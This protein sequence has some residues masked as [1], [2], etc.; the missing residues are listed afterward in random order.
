MTDQQ[1]SSASSNGQDLPP[2]QIA[3][4]ARDLFTENEMDGLIANHEAL[5]TQSR[6]GTGR[7]NADVRR[8]QVVLIDKTE[9]YLW[10]YQ[11]F[12]AVAAEFNRRYFCVDISYIEGNIQLARY[13]S[14]DQGFY[15]WHTDFGDI[16]PHR[17]ISITVQLS[18][19]EDYEGGDLELFFRSPPHKMDRTRGAF[20]AFPSFAL[21]R[22]TPVTRGTRWSLVAWISGARWR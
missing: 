14:S 21:H 17:K 12:W 20:I 19:P 7:G 11:R 22:V 10:L 15:D 6:L 1:R 3:A 2:F 8:S 4:T 13:D 5:L 9:E 16:A 18:R